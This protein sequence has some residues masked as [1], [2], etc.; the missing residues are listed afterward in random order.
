MNSKQLIKN[1]TSVSKVLV[2]IALKKLTKKEKKILR[3]VSSLK[4]TESTTS[5]V[6]EIS[7]NLGYSKSATWL[8]LR[9]LREMNLIFYGKGSKLMISKSAK[10]IINGDGN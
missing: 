2:A 9:S 7:E 6:N 1:E 3:I 8:V 10:I 4:L 5:V